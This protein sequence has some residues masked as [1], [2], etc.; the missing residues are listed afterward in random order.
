[1]MYNLQEI[2]PV[3]SKPIHKIIVALLALVAVSLPFRDQFLVNLFIILVIIAWVFS[4]PAKQLFSKKKNLKNLAAILIFYILHAVSLLYTQNMQEGFFSLEIK[5]SLFVFPLIFYSA[6]FSSKQIKFFITGFVLGC[7]LCCVLCVIHSCYI[8][9]TGIPPT[10]NKGDNFFF[11]TYLSWFQHPSYLSM[12]LTFCC[13]ALFERKLFAKRIQLLLASFFTVFILLLS[14]K[15][16]IVIHFVFL[17]VYFVSSYLAE[18]NFKKLFLFSSVGILI[19][20]SAVFFLPGVKGRFQ[21]VI[22]AFKTEKTDKSATESTAVRML[23]W[24]EATEII[25]KNPLL[26]VSP[27]DTN[28]EL[29]KSYEQN[30]LTGAY[31]K[32]LNAHSQFFQTG[33]GLGLIGV[34]SFL[35]MFIIPMI[36]NRS[37]LLVFFLLITVVNFLTESM[38]QTMAGCIFFGYFYAMLCFEEQESIHS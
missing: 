29:Y 31:A 13:V 1:M 35:S 5:I 2:F 26:G 19:L 11:Y 8:T 24:N 4:R 16:G 25:K 15:S 12:Y 28:D 9:Y 20:V 37:K 32:K 10:G 18:R 3:S 17:S 38:L 14:S 23:I 33:V 22:S 34:A 36:R 27:G 7:T 6:D 21:N 30:G